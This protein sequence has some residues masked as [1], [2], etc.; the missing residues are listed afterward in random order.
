MP[1]ALDSTVKT[2]M[3]R[4]QVVFG[5]GVG[6]FAHRYTLR[7]ASMLIPLLARAQLAL[8]PPHRLRSVR[9]ETGSPVPVP[10]PLAVCQQEE[11]PPAL[12]HCDSN[13]QQHSS[14]LC[15]LFCVRAL[16]ESEISPL[17]A[18]HRPLSGG[19]DTSTTGPSIFDWQVAAPVLRAAEVRAKRT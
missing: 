5:L 6:M 1:P 12:P 3:K 4:T 8:D 7:L 13:L 15:P 18:G 11:C 17:G 19:S 2:A 9:Q 16:S 10:G 14:S